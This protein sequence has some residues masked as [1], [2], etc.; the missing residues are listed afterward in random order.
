MVKIERKRIE[1]WNEK[2]LNS[3]MGGEILKLKENDKIGSL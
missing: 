1:V 2:R 3:S